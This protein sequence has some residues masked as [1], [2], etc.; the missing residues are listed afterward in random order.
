[1]PIHL[2]WG[3]DSAGKENY[4]N[5]LIK[6]CVDPCWISINLSRLEGSDPNQ[7]LQALEEA[8]TPPFGSTSKVILLNNSPF[9]NGCSNQLSSLFEEAI[10][11]IP[12]NTHFI[13]NSSKK[14]DGR[15][16]T[17]KEIQKN[18]KSKQCIEKSFMLPA[19]WDT[20]GQYELV[21]RI[22]KELNLRIDSEAITE[23][24][25]AVGND[26]IR[27]YSELQKL[28]LSIETKSNSLITTKTVKALVAG[29]STNSL[30][31]SN[32]LLTNKPIEAISQL[33][34]LLEQ[35][36]P[37]LRILA[38]L[39][40][41]I[42][43]WLWVSLLEKEGERDVNVI[44]K[45]A[46]IN[47]PKRVYVIRKQLTDQSAEVFLH[48]LSRLLSIEAAIKMGTAPKDAFRDGLLSTI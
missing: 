47:N 1:M 42:R 24:I 5:N 20:K 8:R 35:G 15:L 22:S 16:K 29:V 26:S 37:A 48:L 18:I 40:G 3:D 4:I 43:G 10:E 19:I 28:D 30:Q 45:A 39:I 38:T 2:I 44:A 23:L 31:I 34:A 14:P 6:T 32:S 36:E 46:G 41:Q 7:A 9:C 12:K 33:D 11:L 25:D 27:L 13:L 21:K 17:T